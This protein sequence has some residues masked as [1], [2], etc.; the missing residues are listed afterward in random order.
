[1]ATPHV[2]EGAPST[3]RWLSAEEERAWIAV[4]HLM[5][6][7][8]GAL[9][10]QLQRDSDLNLFEYLALSRLS[11][12]SQWTLR[13]SELAV[14]AGGSLSRLS[15]V[16]KRL[17]ARGYVR[18]EPDAHDRRY[19]H[20][21]LTDV[22]WEKVVAAAPGHVHAVRTLVFEPLGADQISA[23][24]AVGDVLRGQVPIDAAS[25]GLLD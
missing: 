9:D 8:P 12:A 25:S 24:A 21:I 14:L 19:T 3:T 17:E 22:G 10:G 5:L 1:M 18:R 13:M 2:D 16:I 23:L 4:C 20:A 6:Q 7:L 15:N 11:M